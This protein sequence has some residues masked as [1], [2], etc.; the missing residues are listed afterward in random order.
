MCCFHW[1]IFQRKKHIY[2]NLTPS[3]IYTSFTIR[4]LQL[5]NDVYFH[6]IKFYSKTSLF[7]L[8]WYSEIIYFL[9]QSILLKK[10]KYI[11]ICN[12][13]TQIEDRYDNIDVGLSCIY[14]PLKKYN[15]EIV[16]KYNTKEVSLIKCQYV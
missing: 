3:E 2:F 10:C 5:R 7:Y 14:Y 8:I 15:Q 11:L 6:W 9:D 12:C 1:I 13:A 16:L 4:R